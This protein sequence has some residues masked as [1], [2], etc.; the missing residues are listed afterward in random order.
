MAVIGKIRK[1]VWILIV[2]LGLGLAGFIIMDIQSNFFGGGGGRTDFTL[3]EV[4]GKRIDY[5]EFQMAED[6]LSRSSQDIYQTRDYIYSFLVEKAI[7][8]EIADEEGLAVGR[9]E[10]RELQFGT[11][12]SPVVI[13]N[14]GNPQT[15]QVDRQLLEEYRRRIEEGTLTGTFRNFWAF[16][17]KQIIKERLEEK[18]NQLVAKGMYMP[19]WRVLRR[20]HQ[21]NDKADALYVKVPYDRIPD[22]EV[23][24][25][26]DDIQQYI[27]ENPGLYYKKDPTRDVE[28]FINVAVPTAK[29]TAELYQHMLDLKNDFIQAEEDSLFVTTHYG[30]YPLRYFYIDYLDPPL[31]DSIRHMKVGDVVGPYQ[32]NNAFVLAKLV[33][34]KKVPD[35]VRLRAISMSVRTQQDYQRVVATLDSLKQLIDEGKERFDSLANRYS[36]NPEGLGKGGDLGFKAYNELHPNIANIVFFKA[37]PGETYILPTDQALHLVQVTDRKYT[38]DDNTGYRVAYIRENI[39]PSEHTQDSIYDLMVDL[40]TQYRDYS[41]L[42]SALANR[43]DIRTELVKGVKKN[44][45]SLGSLGSESSSREIVRWAFDPSTEVGDVSPEVYIFTSP[46]NFREKFVVAALTGSYPEGQASVDEVRESVVPILINRKK[47]QRIAEQLGAA[48]LQVAADKFELPID[49][50]NQVTFL[51]EFFGKEGKEPRVVGNLFGLAKGAQRGSQGVGGYYVIKKVEEYIAP[52]PDN[53]AT[54]RRINTSQYPTRVSK[55]LLPSLVDKADVED[56]R[57]KFY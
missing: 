12:L 46:L 48:D 7:L 42:K 16:Q 37:K 6:V 22:A 39:I 55:F 38:L 18:L 30:E 41:S 2:L 44:D 50:A 29:D 56:N 57:F 40:M 3:A 1:N 4:D 49:T 35:S 54:W 28:L 9:D 26:D 53:L 11:R 15:G 10:L 33:D 5:R 32:H 24:V 43:D 23:Q 52:D 31:R 47:A 21:N 27:E 34:V 13:R 20:F 8:D 51:F 14:L 36:Q 19:R 17:E 45:H 25:T